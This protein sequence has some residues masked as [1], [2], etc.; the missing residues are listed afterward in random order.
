MIYH[1]GGNNLNGL[2]EDVAKVTTSLIKYLDRFDSIAVQGL[3]GVTVG[4]LASRQIGKPLVIV[5]KPN[6][7]S[8]S[9]QPLV[10]GEHLGERVLFL[11]DFISMGE[12]RDRVK[13]AVERAGAK[14]VGT[15]EYCHIFMTEGDYD[16]GLN[17]YQEVT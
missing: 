6:E 14:L 1:N 5:R 15:L 9:S 4:L 3:S 17:W 2:D 7:G 12:T 13:K 8:H 11:D 10:N 16:D